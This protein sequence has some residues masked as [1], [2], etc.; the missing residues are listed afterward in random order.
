MTRPR[1]RRR[2]APDPWDVGFGAA[3]LALAVAA[4]SWWFPHD[5]KGGFIE[6]SVGGRRVP[7][8]AFFPVLLAVALAV[9]AAVQVLLALLGRGARAPA[10][11]ADPDAGRLTARDMR[12]LASFHVVVL[13]GLALMYGLGPAAV[14]AAKALGLTDLDYRQL[15]DTAPWKYLGYLAG[16]FVMTAGLIVYSEGRLRR[17]ALVT[18][19]IVLVCAVLLFDVALTNVL[20]PPNAD[21]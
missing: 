19:V 2:E 17:R 6:A 4:L 9:L 10:R 1:G 13:S 5:I 12:F 3:L 7:G 15:A 16:G 20:L 21:Q 18:V 8:D 14:A 11:D